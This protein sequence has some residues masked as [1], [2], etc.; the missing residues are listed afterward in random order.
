VKN[1]VVYL[2]FFKTLTSC[3]GHINLSFG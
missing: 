1:T 3:T 2:L